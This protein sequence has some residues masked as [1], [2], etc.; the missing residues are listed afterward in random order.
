MALYTTGSA[1]SGTR[2]MQPWWKK[3]TNFG[4]PPKGA[5]LTQ[6]AFNG[7]KNYTFPSTRYALAV[8]PI[9]DLAYATHAAGRARSWNMLYADGS[10]KGVVV[11]NR[12]GRAGG[13]WI[14][15][16]DLLGFLEAVADGGKANTVNPTWNTDYN[17]MP[18]N[19]R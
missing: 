15:L 4:K 5:I 16:L 1:T 13:D 8:D 3:I 19:P 2:Y 7:D 10:V 11:D 12:V 9:N 14:R 18:V 17:N 6:T